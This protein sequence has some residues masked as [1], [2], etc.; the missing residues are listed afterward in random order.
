MTNEKRIEFL[1]RLI[2]AGKDGL[3]NESLSDEENRFVRELLHD[4]EA[5]HFDVFREEGN[6][7]VRTGQFAFAR[8]GTHEQ[9]YVARGWARYTREGVLVTNEGRRHLKLV[10]KTEDD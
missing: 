6:K 5:G 4:G 8:Y 9:L 10:P 7:S 2:A 3:A 1:E